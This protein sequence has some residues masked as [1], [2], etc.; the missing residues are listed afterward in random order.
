[1]G[2]GKG[3]GAGL[4]SVLKKLFTTPT[5]LVYVAMVALSLL[6]WELPGFVMNVA[7][8]AGNANSFLAMLCIGILFEVRFPREG[9]AH[10]G[11]GPGRAV[12][13]VRHWRLW[14]CGFGCRFR[15]KWHARW[16]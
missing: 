5:F 13:G 14:F 6:H 12:H 16:W 11:P 4:G 8:M 7:V 10:G 15:G 3:R 9:R 2:D 1:M